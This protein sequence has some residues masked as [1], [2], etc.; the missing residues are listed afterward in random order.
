MTILFKTVNSKLPFWLVWSATR[1]DTISQQCFRQVVL[2]QMNKLFLTI[3]RISDH[4]RIW[5]PTWIGPIGF[6]TLAFCIY[7]R[8]KW[9]HWHAEIPGNQ[10]L[11]IRRCQV[12]PRETHQH[13]IP[14]LENRSSR[15]LK[16]S[17]LL[18]ETFRDN[19]ES[20]RP[21]HL[22]LLLCCRN[23]L[24]QPSN[25]LKKHNST[26]SCII[27]TITSHIRYPNEEINL[28]FF[29]PSENSFFFVRQERL[30]VL[31]CLSS[32]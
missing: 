15:R 26:R 25:F 3:F 31:Y 1:K 7:G 11:W 18:R 27:P 4:W 2:K 24:Q 6:G 32:F 23:T 10:R 8:G 13:W 21:P 14:W 17:L 28:W 12:F 9:W 22:L 29:N 30:I 20:G 5:R 19:L 16:I